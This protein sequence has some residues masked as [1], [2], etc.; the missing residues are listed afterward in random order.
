MNRHIKTAIISVMI[1]T[2]VLIGFCTF[3]TAE[4]MKA[5]DLFGRD[6]NKLFDQET[7]PSEYTIES[8]ITGLS[9]DWDNGSLEIISY[10]G[11][12]V[13]IVGNDT[14]DTYSDTYI[15][16]E[17]TD[18][19]LHVFIESDLSLPFTRDNDTN[20]SCTVLIPES[21]LP[22]LKNDITVNADDAD[23]TIVLME[24]S[25]LFVTTVSGDIFVQE[26]TADYIG[27]TTVDGNIRAD[28]NRTAVLKYASVSGDIQSS[29]GVKD[30]ILNSVSGNIDCAFET[31]FTRA[32]FKT[33]SGNIDIFIP[34]ND[35]IKINL[36]T[37]SGGFDC[38]NDLENDNEIYLYE[39]G[40]NTA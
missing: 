34:Q 8:D 30:A 19:I 20:F 3:G 15:D 10:S 40:K 25:R 12:T 37:V 1:F 6:L 4:N 21:I 32:D 18:G 11:D 39:N 38:A 22:D 24:S 29:A 26:V 27:L 5:Q 16:Y 17:I 7:H 13:Q 33:T 36:H 31:M 2:V 9:V 14:D 28:S 35:G 23:I